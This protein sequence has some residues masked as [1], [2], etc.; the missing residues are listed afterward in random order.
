MIVP[1][2]H[3]RGDQIPGQY[4]VFSVNCAGHDPGKR[5]DHP[6]FIV[7]DVAAIFANDILAMAR[8]DFDRSLVTHGPGDDVQTR[9]AAEDFCRPILKAVD[10]RI[11]AI[12]IISHLGIVHSRSHRRRRLGYSIAA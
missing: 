5:R 4:S 10:G 1:A 9:F 12:D 8:Q 7:V 2:A 6:H 3:V 11:F